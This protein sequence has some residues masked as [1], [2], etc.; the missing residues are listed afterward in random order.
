MPAFYCILFVGRKVKVRGCQPFAKVLMATNLLVLECRRDMNG[1]KNESK[2]SPLTVIFIP[3]CV[4][5]SMTTLLK[6]HF[7]AFSAIYKQRA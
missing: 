6:V 2:I 4:G 5:S 1:Q 7:F 3:V